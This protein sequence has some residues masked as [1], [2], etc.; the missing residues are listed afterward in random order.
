MG[1]ATALPPIAHTAAISRFAISKDSRAQF[2]LTLHASA[3]PGAEIQSMASHMALG[4][5]AIVF[6]LQA[7]NPVEF[8]CPVMEP[9]LIRLL[10]RFGI[11]F[12]AVPL[13]EY[14]GL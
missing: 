4:L 2:G 6:G 13:I 7:R 8:I 11:H 14:H 12:R 9:S 5:M 3:T 1:G 10:S